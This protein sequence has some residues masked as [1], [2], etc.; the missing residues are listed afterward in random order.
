M[1][2]WGWVVVAAVSIAAAGG[3]L[4]L[5]SRG[6]E[7]V[8]VDVGEVARRPVF[9]SFVTASGEVVASRYADI[10]SSVMGR[11][12]DLEVAEGQRVARGAVLARID[13]VQ[14]ES[15]ATAAVAQLRALEAE[16]AA[17]R[18]RA[19]ETK[20]ALTRSTALN[21]DGVLPRAELDSA[22]AAD[23]TARAQAEAAERRV[24]QGRAQV[25]RAQDAL[26]KTE[27]T[28]PMDG[29]ITRLAV[30]EGEMVVMGVQNQPGTILMTLSDLSTINAEVK[31]AEADVLRLKPGQPAFVTLEAAPGRELPG[32]V[33]E[34]G[35]SALPVTG[36]GAA[37]REFRV[38]VRL[39]EPDPALRP[40][41]TCDVRILAD[42]VR[43]A[44][45]LPLQAVVLRP[46]P[47][48]KDRT[49]VFAV[50]E[51]K[52][53]FEPVETGIVGGLDVEVRGLA[54]G[55]RVAAG[56]FQVLR[57]LEDGMAVRPR[58]AER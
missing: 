9:Q 23:D 25:R 6:E 21:A 51:G 4:L 13:P 44:L 36:A 33:V 54:A 55:A 8:A 22:Q 35:A 45:T 30:R 53:V 42:E 15:D 2:R 24:A 27:I 10:G 34:I 26:A 19:E 5:R 7:A 48:G 43:D 17:A 20:R 16:A 47:D 39:D 14:A 49:G 29:V 46:G 52:A 32:R 18:A 40:G 57:E 50:R 58:D 28:A 31:V 3:A 12:V 56:P 37:A 41:L 11:L 38:V 1:K